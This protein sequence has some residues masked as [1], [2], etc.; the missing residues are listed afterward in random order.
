MICADASGKPGLT[1]KFVST[2][3]IDFYIDKGMIHIADTKVERRYGDFF[4]RQ[5]T[6][7]EDIYQFVSTLKL[8]QKKKQPYVKTATVTAAPATT[9]NAVTNA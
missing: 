6:S 7:F 4:L 9:E 3:D 2:S 8:Q 5:I 1:G